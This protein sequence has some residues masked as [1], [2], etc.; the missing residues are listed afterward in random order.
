M[1]QDKRIALR[2]PSK[3]REQIEQLIHE[4]KF[5]KISQVVRD[6]LQLYFSKEGQAL[7]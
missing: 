2:L 5:K 4:G 1:Q 6:A 3:E 7:Y